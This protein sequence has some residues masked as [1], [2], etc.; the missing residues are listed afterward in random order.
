MGRIDPERRRNWVD[1]FTAARP[2]MA[3]VLGSESESDAL[4]E[5]FFAYQDRPDTASYTALYFA[6]GTVPKNA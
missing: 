6:S 5:A 2:Y 1:Q 3:R 4:I